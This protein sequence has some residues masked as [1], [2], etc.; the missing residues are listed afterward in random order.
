MRRSIA[1]ILAIFLLGFGCLGEM[2]HQGG[3]AESAAQT[4][5][6]DLDSDESP[7]YLVYD[8]SPNTYSEAGMTIQ[9]QVTVTVETTSFYTGMT[10]NLTDVDLLIADQSM[11]EFSKSRIQADT[12]CSQAIGL[13][14]VVCSDVATCSR[15]CSSASIKCKRIAAAHEEVLAGSMISYVKSNNDIRSLLLDARRMVLDL[16]QGSDDDRD[17]FLGKTRDIVARVAEINS[18]P[19]YTSGDIALCEHSDFG[20]VPYLVEAAQKVGPY[21]TQNTSY[22]YHVLLS[23]KPQAKTQSSDLGIEVAGISLADKIP[24]SAVLDMES[25]SSIQTVYASSAGGNVIV[26]W[27]SP[28]PSKEG[29]LLY[30]D[31]RSTEPPE[32]VI[33]ALRSPELKVR[34]INLIPLI[35]TNLMLVSVNGM[36]NNYFVAYGAAVGLTL[37]MIFFLYNVFVLAFTMISEKAAG[38]SFTTG[39]RKAFGRTDVRWRTD[40][41]VAIVFMAAGFYISTAWAVQ[42]VTPPPL[43]ESFDVL[44]R[45]DMGVISIGLMVIGVLMLYFALENFLKITILERAYGMVIRQEKDMFLAKAA[46]LKEKIKE[47]EALVEEYAKEDFDVSKEY[48]VLTIVKGEKVD[49]L[50]KD[51]SA[52]SKALIDDYLSRVDTAISSLKG[53]KKLADENWPRWK[54]NVAKLLD[55]QG[56]VYTASLITIPASLRGW[57]LGRFAK[58]TGMEGLSFDRDAI[59][60]KKV[61]PEQLVQDLVGKGLIKGA[62]VFKQDK[63]VFSEFAEG[64]TTM[65][66]ALGLKLLGY[67]RSLSRNLGQHNPQSFAALGDKVVVVMMRSRVHDSLV[68]VGKEHFRDAIEQWKTKMKA[69]E[70]G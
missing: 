52:R 43:L 31:F 58:E 21:T 47:L 44:I 46:T 54:D 30:Y 18:N 34:T 8:F 11:E 16:R 28:K 36:I 35:P 26:N 2:P 29:Y 69:F 33:P 19:I 70:S 63:V 64:G 27:T 39:F 15:L 7:D 32:T 66:T 59:K 42:P 61:S 48:D 6:T 9:R 10:P 51:M 1:V 4:A 3:K 49:V 22:R 12:A 65:M 62:I 57:A 25:I 17:T 53:R 68:F 50:T 20:I 60:K 67:L 14:N 24:A 13:S 41:V 45:S 40:I 38:A 37:A 5:A 55:E 56:E 23:V